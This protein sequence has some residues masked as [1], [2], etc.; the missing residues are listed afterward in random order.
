[1]GEDR[2]PKDP[3]FDILNWWRVQQCRYPVL[4]KMARDI[5]AI[6]VSTVASE[7]ASSAGGRVLDTFRTSLT[8]RMVEALVCTQDWLRASRTP[9]FLDDTFREIEN[10]EEES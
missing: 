6:P 2:E 3:K 8:P 5:L 7:S 1:M 10:L 9:I 4:A